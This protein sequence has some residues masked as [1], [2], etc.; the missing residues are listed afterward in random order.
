MRSIS[1]LSSLAVF[2]PLLLSVTT[3]TARAQVTSESEYQKHVAPILE[4][5][6]VKCH[7]A[8]SKKGGVSFETD[9]AKHLVADQ[10]LWLN[11]LK[12]LRSG[13]M[14]P[15]GKA[16]PTAEQLVTIEKWIKY[17]AFGIDPA[18]PDPGRVTLRRLNRTEYRNTIFDL[19]GVDFNI[20]L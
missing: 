16:R 7:D 1:T 6:C 2:V 14:P 17:S 11:C 19:L 4:Q 3:S 8:D 20:L 9:S 15:K 12:M 18:N 5:Y 13:L 10:E